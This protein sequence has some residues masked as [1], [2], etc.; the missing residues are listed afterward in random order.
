MGLFHGLLEIAKPHLIAK[1]IVRFPSILDGRG[2]VRFRR[3]PIGLDR[4]CDT[5]LRHSSSWR[6]RPCACGRRPDR[7]A[8]YPANRR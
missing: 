8:G 3:S 1:R 6:P 7:C 2:I 4:S 5:A